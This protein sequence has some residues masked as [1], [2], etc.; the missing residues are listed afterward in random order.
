MH[1][2][3]LALGQL[4]FT[5]EVETGSGADAGHR[6]IRT[7]A[8]DQ[9]APRHLHHTRLRTLG[10]GR[11]TWHPL[12]SLPQTA[13]PPTAR[14]RLELWRERAGSWHTSDYFG[15]TVAHRACVF[16]SLLFRSC[17]PALRLPRKPPDPFQ[18]GNVIETGRMSLAV[19][20]AHRVNCLRS[21][22]PWFGS[23]PAEAA[24]ARPVRC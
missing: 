4:V 2:V 14:P 21:R 9:S 7:S 18:R 23:G 11:G 22:A 8:V 5:R 19:S 20:I 13:R 1:K 16:Q 15:L 17:E 6:L 12:R 24:L 10:S 3:R